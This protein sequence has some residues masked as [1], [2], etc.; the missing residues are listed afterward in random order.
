MVT[1]HAS[2]GTLPRNIDYMVRETYSWF[3]HS[4]KSQLAYKRLY[5]TMNDGKTPLQITRVCDTRW[6]SVEPAVTRILKQWDILRSHSQ[7]TVNSILCVRSGLQRR[8]TCCYSYELPRSVTSKIGTMQA[9]SDS[10]K[11]GTSSSASR[12]EDADDVISFL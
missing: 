6:L 2:D 1:L 12:I 11:E 9:Y 3:S 8:E 10:Y 7:V 5:E 4:S